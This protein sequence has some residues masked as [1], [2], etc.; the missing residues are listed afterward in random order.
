MQPGRTR[1][2]NQCNDRNERAEGGTGQDRA[3]RDSG[4]SERLWCRITAR[5]AGA[6]PQHERSRQGV[7]GIAGAGHVLL[8]RHEL[9]GFNATLH[10]SCLRSRDTPEKKV[11]TTTLSSASLPS[12]TVSPPY[13]LN[14]AHPIPSQHKILVACKYV[15][16]NITN[17]RGGSCCRRRLCDKITPSF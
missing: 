7:G 16:L 3:G 13:M 10:V 4:S 11:L 5:K 12:L 6:N 1:R 17:R 9:K 15:L 2:N 8:L 14:Y